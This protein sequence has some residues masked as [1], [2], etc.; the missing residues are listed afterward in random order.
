MGSPSASKILEMIIGERLSDWIAED[1]NWALLIPWIMVMLLASN[2]II[3]A[4][5]RQRIWERFWESW[6]GRIIIGYVCITG[7]AI[8]GCYLNQEPHLLMGA[9]PLLVIGAVFVGL[10]F[11]KRSQALPD[12]KIVVAIAL[13]KAVTPGAQED[14]G[15]VRHWLIRELRM[16]EEQDRP[17]QVRDDEAI[18]AGSSEGDRHEN[19]KRAFRNK[20]H[21]VIWGDVQKE[22]DIPWVTPRMTIATQPHSVRLDHVKLRD[23]PPSFETDRIIFRKRLAEELADIPVFVHGMAYFKLRKW[24]EAREKFTHVDSDIG[25]LYTALCLYEEAEFSLNP[26]PLLEEAIRTYDQIASTHLG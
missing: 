21:I 2:L 9:A 10:G 11:F 13:F 14:A 15:N 1:H 20:A 5:R 19:A 7:G 18:I 26:T 8:Y 6:M 3:P 12:D 4:L 25:R 24:K 22:G 23:F 17:I 16:K